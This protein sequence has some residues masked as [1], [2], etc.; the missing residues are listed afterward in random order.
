MQPLVQWQRSREFNSSV[1]NICNNGLNISQKISILYIEYN[2]SD[3]TVH[4]QTAIAMLEKLGRIISKKNGDSRLSRKTPSKMKWWKEWNN[5]I[6]YMDQT[7]NLNKQ[8][9]NQD[10]T[11]PTWLCLHLLNNI[12]SFIQQLSDSFD[13]NFEA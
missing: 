2:D 8:M 4:S 3:V 12:I 6:N 13:V 7:S 1:Q 10:C 9:W 5:L 11:L